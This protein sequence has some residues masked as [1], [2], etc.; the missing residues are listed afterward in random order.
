M[1]SH[2]PTADR[3]VLIVLDGLRPEFVTDELMPHL[4][5]F[6]AGGVRFT[7]SHAVLPTVTRCN[8]A[9]IASGTLPRTHGIPGNRFVA[10]ALESA[11]LNAGDHRDLE[12]LRKI[13][14]GTVT[15][16]PTLADAIHE[17][18]GRT[19]VLGTGT[20]GAAVLQ[21]PEA[22]ANGDVLIHPAVV[23]GV[24]MA[25]VVAA[26]GPIPKSATPATELNRYF[27][28]LATEF[29]IP[30]LRPELLIFWHTDPDRSQHA[31]GP[32]TE[33]SLRALRDAD[34][35]V[36]AILGA[37]EADTV[38]AILSDHGFVTNTGTVDIEARLRGAGLLDAGSE[39]A[40]VASGLVYLDGVDEALERR[41]RT[42]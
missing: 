12:R 24:E 27:T 41:L 19:V 14:N 25:A 8:S 15:F 42:H 30:E 11:H 26:F 10:R 6:A 18:G 16:A 40:H 17:A 2:R 21:N 13:R 36:A 1:P 28:R 20:P 37:V 4:T 29:V 9:T 7:D 33:Q 3:A 35:N 34:V 31:E 39:P 5:E 23:E 38:V 22:G 32:G